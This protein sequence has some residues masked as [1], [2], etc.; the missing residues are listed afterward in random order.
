MFRFYFILMLFLITCT[1]QK[2]EAPSEKFSAIGPDENFQMMVRIIDVQHTGDQLKL[3]AIFANESEILTYE[4]GDTLTL[5]PNFVRK[6][7][8]PVQMDDEFN[9][10]MMSLKDLEDNSTIT[11]SVKFRGSAGKRHGLIMDWFK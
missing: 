3:T 11:V 2:S 8:L 10:K 7:G 9:S 5:Y 1:G 6:E 4:K